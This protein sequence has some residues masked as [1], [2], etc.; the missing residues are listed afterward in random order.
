[1]PASAARPNAC[2][3]KADDLDGIVRVRRRPTP[4]ISS[5]SGPKQPLVLGLV[6]RLEAAGIKAFGPTAAAAALEGSKGFMKDL[7]AKYGIPTA[8]YGRFT[9]AERRP[10]LRPRNAA[11]RSW[12]R[13]TGWPPARA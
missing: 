4:S 1:M 3:I 5:W 11:R 2:R 6:D 10:R 13:P 12:S 8:A 9:D 7:C